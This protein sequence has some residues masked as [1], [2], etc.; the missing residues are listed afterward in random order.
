MLSFNSQTSLR[1]YIEET[2]I[3]ILDRKIIIS[4]ESNLYNEG[5]DSLNIVTLIIE[6]EN[7]L[8]IEIQDNDLSMENFKDL[9]SIE[10]FLKK[11][12]V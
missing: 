1:N 7:D 6:F 9:T 11:Y 10:N 5:L 4:N 8:G 2:L 3:K 12:G